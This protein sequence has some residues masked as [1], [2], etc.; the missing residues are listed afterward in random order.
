MRTELFLRHVY[1]LFCWLFA[2]SM[3]KTQILQHVLKRQVEHQICCF[4]R[5]PNF[6]LK[7][8]WGNKHIDFLHEN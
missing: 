6:A 7:K 3:N 5:A 8:N 2:L 1:V 4:F